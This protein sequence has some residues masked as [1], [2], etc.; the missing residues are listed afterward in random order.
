M[1]KTNVILQTK[2][3]SMFKLLKHN[4]RIVE[5]HVQDLIKSFT[6]RPHLR[7]AR[8]VL[9]NDKHEI[10]D[11]QHRVKASER[12]GIEVFYMV[13]EGLTISDARLLNALQRTW[14]LLDYAESYASDGH[15]EYEKFLAMHEKYKIPAMALVAYMS[16]RQDQGMRKQF[17]IGEFKT[18]EQRLILDY[19]QKLEDFAPFLKGWNEERFAMAAF[20]LFRNDVYDH[21]RM[22]TKLENAKIQRQPSR[23]EYLRELEN[24]YNMD[25]RLEN[26]VRFF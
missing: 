7:P 17:K 10:I 13:V 22:L 16:G 12:M 6:D 18:T 9:I 21:K 5:Y 15:A 2:D 8:P 1:E 4:R 23:L 11:G 24:I 3:Y 25:T 14:S 26:R 20:T 19:L